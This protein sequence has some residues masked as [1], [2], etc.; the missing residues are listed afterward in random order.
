M[1]STTDFRSGA[2][3]EIDSVPYSIIEFQKVKP[4]KGGA[5]VRTKLK[6]LK[7][8]GVIDR[9]FRSG[10]K[11]DEPNVDECEMQFLYAS[12]DSYSFMDSSS[13]EQFSYDKSQLGDNTDL[14]KEDTLVKILLYNGVPI[15]VELP[16]FMELKVVETDPGHRG[17]TATGGTKLAKVETGASVKVPLYLENG[18]MIRIDTRSREYVERI[19]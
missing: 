10:E 2:R 7:T 5:F 19:R 4:G 18:E 9:T 14:L 1:I 3:V 16:N 17:D 13:Y 6:N 15:S 12:G 11:L 8:G